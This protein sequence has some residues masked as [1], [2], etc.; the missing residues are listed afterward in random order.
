MGRQADHAR[1]VG[2]GEVAGPKEQVSPQVE[3]SMQELLELTHEALRGDR[4]GRDGHLGI[5]RRGEVAYRRTVDLRK[6]QP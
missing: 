4:T 5:R 6:P 1:T 2:Q 3:G